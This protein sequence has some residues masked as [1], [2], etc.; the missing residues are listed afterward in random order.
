MK[1]EFSNDEVKAVLEE[2]V[3]KMFTIGPNQ[4]VKAQAKSYHGIDAVVHI[5]NKD[6]KSAQED[7]E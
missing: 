5:T 6:D 4:R 3:R 2:A 7:G 1:I